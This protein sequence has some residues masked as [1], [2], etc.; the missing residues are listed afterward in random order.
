MQGN[1]YI[2]QI[3][4][5]YILSD[6]IIAQKISADF[7][8]IKT[9]QECYLLSKEYL[10]KY[11]KAP[12]ATELKELIKIANKEDI[13]TNDIIDILYAAKNSL[14]EFTSEWL[15]DNSTSWAQWKN[16]INSL[17]S[18]LAYVKINESEISVENVKEIMEHAKSHFNKNCIIE[19]E[20]VTDSG[21]DFWDASSHKQQKLIRSSTGY[22]F[23]DI[24]L[25]GGY[26]PGCL[27]CFVGAPKIGKSVWLQNLC[28]TSVKK[29]E[30][31]IYIS[32]ELPEEMINSRIGSNM[33]SI[34]SL[35][36]EKYSN[37]EILFK[38]RINNFKKSQIVPPGKLFVK[39]FPTSTLSTVDLE[40]FILAKE[41][42]LSTENNKFKFKNVFVDYINIMRNY[43]NPN[44]E[45]TYMKIKQIAEDLKAIGI[46]N[47]WSIVTATQTK[48]SQYESN[49]MSPQQVAE[50]SGLGAT[51]D[52]MFGI[53]A[54]PIMKQQ[55]QYYL[56]CIYD[57]VAP[58]DNKRK[59]YILQKEFLRLI[60]DKESPIEDVSMMIN[61]NPPSQN[62]SYFNQ[63]IK[64]KNNNENIN[65]NQNN[66]Q[67]LP[68]FSK[69]LLDNKSN[70]LNIEQASNHVLSGLIN[71]TGDK[72]F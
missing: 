43:R 17:K 13:L 71:V 31:N 29:G 51:V 11:H 54:D 9:I 63:N 46:K 55:G 70:N 3:F 40:A 64:N 27:V 2:Q 58:E 33:F 1:T 60:E 22:D 36:Y 66:I 20:D 59:H 4:Y 44:S 50:S 34:P 42:E 7:F 61:L 47:N 10:M 38:E 68:I 62:K 39:M 72:L 23:I 45:N 48:V 21:A 28:A 35:D 49:D 12:T 57:R 5:H 37:D 69:S 18:T 56:K 6:I 52:V 41:D 25:K 30:H 32:L 8:D 67:T 16:F 24:C 65:M 15:F 19:F 26:Y 14:S 53:I